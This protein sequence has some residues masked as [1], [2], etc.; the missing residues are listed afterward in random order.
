MAISPSWW[1]HFIAERK[2]WPWLLV[3]LSDSSNSNFR[4]YNLV[5]VKV[6]CL[7]YIYKASKQEGIMLGR[8]EIAAAVMA[9]ILSSFYLLHCIDCCQQSLFSIQTRSCWK[10]L[11]SPL[12]SKTTHQRSLLTGPSIYSPNLVIFTNLITITGGQLI[13]GLQ[14]HQP[15]KKKKKRIKLCVMIIYVSFSSLIFELTFMLSLLPLIEWSLVVV[16]VKV[17]LYIIITSRAWNFN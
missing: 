13:M 8:S 1:L 11:L 16:S 7:N 4:S 14:Q 2:H 3:L 9:L 17:L 6:M 12:T 10:A 15:K 5:A